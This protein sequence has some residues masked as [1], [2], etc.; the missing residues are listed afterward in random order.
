MRREKTLVIRADA[1][2][3]MGAG[4][5]MRC[6][7]LAEAWRDAG[8]DVIYCGQIDSDSLR[9][10]IS[11]AGF[12]YFETGL[13]IADTIDILHEHNLAGCWVVL[14]GYHFGP[15]WQFELV[16]AGYLVAVV[17]DGGRLAN[18]AAHVILGVEEEAETT[19]YAALPSTLIVAGSRFRLLR[20]DFAQVKRKNVDDTVIL[21]TFGGADSANTTRSA[22]LALDKVL[23]PQDKVLVVL[24]SL[25]CHAPSIKEALDGV[26]YGYELFQDVDNM[27]TLYA[28][29]KLALS[30]GGLAAWEMALSGLP[31]ILVPVADNQKAGMGC[32][33]KAGAAM[34]LAGPEDLLTEDFVVLITTIL[35]TPS[36]LL[37][38]SARARDVCDG[39]G[40]MRVSHILATLA[41]KNCASNFV[42]RLAK[43]ADM[44]SIFRLANNPI[45]RRNSFSP[46]A[47]SLKQHAA[48]YAE[49]LTSSHTAIF[50]LELAGVIVA[51]T[52]FD[53]ISD[54]AEIDI[55]VH[56]ALHGRGL[57]T[58]ILR[59][60]AAHAA[61]RFGVN[62][63]RAR[64]L[65]SNSE[66]QRC[67]ARA[68]FR[69]SGFDII[70]GQNCILFTWETS[71]M[72]TFLE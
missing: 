63:L 71:D 5:V 28:R 11:V 20:K 69:E 67:F 14:D 16:N 33:I 36:K 17:D 6:L 10:K 41:D 35:K 64:V 34:S 57:G 7:A 13:A 18:Y 51:L 32:L 54:F 66:S 21:I 31:T 15:E 3:S 26:G 38:M 55:A 19:T 68:G 45:V 47:I 42:L 52:R 53:K 27:T 23:R 50:V 49:R 25:N 8:N 1:T 65:E 70:K 44:E 40:A 12:P 72:D 61:A 60:S 58:R 37:E 22:V 62:I 48:W 43:P 9:R 56:P 46:E 4:H 30:A 2:P 24:G 39:N 59:E 29:A